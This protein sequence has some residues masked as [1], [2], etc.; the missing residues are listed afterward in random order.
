M[1]A[2][3]IINKN[4]F[5]IR[6]LVH[7]GRTD[8]NVI[9]LILCESYFRKKK[10]RIIEYF[11]MPFL[12]LINRNRFNKLSIGI[13]QIQLKH[14]IKFKKNKSPISLS[15]YSSY[16][17]VLNNYDL[18]NELVKQN[19]NLDYTDSKLIA[20]HTGETRKYHF[21]LFQELK[22]QIKTAPNTV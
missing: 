18:I 15:A 5:L 3:S 19:L 1:I 11:A 10:D 22:R 20:F 16:F 7:S 4:T 8:L 21:D 13:G 12:Y 14:W 6:K 9:A 17:S 2:K